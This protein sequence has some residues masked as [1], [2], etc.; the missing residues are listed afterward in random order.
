[1]AESTEGIQRAES[2]RIK[3]KR[4]RHKQSIYGRDLEKVDEGIQPPKKRE[5]SEARRKY[6]HDK[7]KNNLS[8]GKKDGPWVTLASGKTVKPLPHSVQP[9]GGGGKRE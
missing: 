7:L 5:N 3:K 2:N 1:M 8:V 9:E 6:R 4:V